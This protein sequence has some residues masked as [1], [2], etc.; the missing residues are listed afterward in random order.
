MILL[1]SSKEVSFEKP[2]LGHDAFHR[3]RPLR[4]I[5][6]IVWHVDN[7]TDDDDDDLCMTTVVTCV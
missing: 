7:N 2:D 6:S 4:V 1:R 5:L 3:R